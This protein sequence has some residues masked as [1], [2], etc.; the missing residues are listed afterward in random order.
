MA[1]RALWLAAMWLMRRLRNEAPAVPNIAKLQCAA[2]MYSPP[3]KRYAHK[4]KL[5]TVFFKGLVGYLKKMLNFFS[6]ILQ[7]LSIWAFS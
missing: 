7:P 2:I 5:E 6:G 1:A 4:N 3:R